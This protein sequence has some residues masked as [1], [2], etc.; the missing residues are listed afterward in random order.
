M[1]RS[2]HREGKTAITGTV[3]NSFSF[4]SCVWWHNNEKKD[5]KEDDC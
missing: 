3:I 5:E 2:A 4:F 1:K